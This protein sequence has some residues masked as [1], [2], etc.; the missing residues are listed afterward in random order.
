MSDSAKPELH[1]SQISLYTHCGMA[2]EFRYVKGKIIP[3]GVALVTGIANHDSAQK[4]LQSKIDSGSLLPEEQVLE[5]TAS[6]VHRLWEQGVTLDYNERA[7][8]EATVRGRTL[9][10][11]VKLSRLHH[12][13][14]APVIEPV[15]VE[16]T[17]KL[18]LPQYPVDL[19]GTIDV[20]EHGGLR[21]LKCYGKKPSPVEADRSLQLTLYALAKKTLDRAHPKRISLDVLVKNKTPKIVTQTTTRNEGDYRSLL[22]RVSVV[23][24]AI[25][26]GI[27]IPATP[28][29]WRCSV[30]FCGYYH[31]CPYGTRRRTS[32]S[33]AA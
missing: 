23:S 32:V 8:G 21:D 29:D 4:N 16:R 7:T 13:T 2:Y 11:A 24:D 19:V 30:K 25:Q 27:F 31:I 33:M 14:L 5:L 22:A 17:F 15:A 18:I 6:A 26:K 9:D 28:D 3:P 12:R 1:Q 10:V 20:E